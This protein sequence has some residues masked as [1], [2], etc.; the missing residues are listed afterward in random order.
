M[1]GAHEKDPG[2]IDYREFGW[3]AKKYL[4]PSILPA[5]HHYDGNLIYDDPSRSHPDEKQKPKIN[6]Y[7]YN[8][9]KEPEEPKKIVPIIDRK[10]LRRKWRKFQARERIPFQ[11]EDP[12]DR[13]EPIDTDYH[14]KDREVVH[15]EKD[16]SRITKRKNADSLKDKSA[17]D[18]SDENISTEFGDKGWCPFLK[19]EFENY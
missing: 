14:K 3:N 9:E 16:Q 2:G 8:F 11:H 10:K 13:Y 15:L 7:I 5:R 6:L 19:F 18:T 12:Y 1:H 4:Y 17:T